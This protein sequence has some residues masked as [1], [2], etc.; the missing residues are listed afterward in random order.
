MFIKNNNDRDIDDD[1]DDDDDAAVV[2]FLNL[3]LA[4]LLCYLCFDG[5]MLPLHRELCA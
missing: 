3:R 2:E 5:V 4:V 1:D